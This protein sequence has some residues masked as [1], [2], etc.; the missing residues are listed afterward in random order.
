MRVSD[1]KIYE[2]MSDS[3]LLKYVC[4]KNK[5]ECSKVTNWRIYKKSIDAR[6]KN[7]VHYNY[8]KKRIY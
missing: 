4:K 7:R 8:T 5:I 3:D 2:D 1:I 6:D